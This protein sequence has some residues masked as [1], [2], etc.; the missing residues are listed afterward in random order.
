MS[1]V[2]NASRVHLQNKG[3]TLALE[4]LA[5]RFGVSLRVLRTIGQ[6]ALVLPAGMSADA[7]FARARIEAESTGFKEGWPCEW[8]SPE[9]AGFTIVIRLTIQNDLVISFVH[10]SGQQP[11]VGQP[12]AVVLRAGANNQQSGNIVFLSPSD[13]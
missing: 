9:D 7:W 12:I 2:L 8:I 13:C 11:E 10:P 5:A 6:D 4:M 1:L 3:L